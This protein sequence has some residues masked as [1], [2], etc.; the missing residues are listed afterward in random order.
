MF[1]I[2]CF[3]L[4]IWNRLCHVIAHGDLG[5]N[6]LDHVGRFNAGQ[7]LIEALETKS[8]PRVVEAE[9]VEDGGVQVTYVHAIAY[10]IETEVIAF[11]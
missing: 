9:Q 3:G 1:R 4:S 11:P 6:V 7:L 10:H 5:Q 8:E 2:W